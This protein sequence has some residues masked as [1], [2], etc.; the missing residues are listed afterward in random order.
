[1]SKHRR[2][3][4]PTASTT[5]TIGTNAPRGDPLYVKSSAP[6]GTNGTISTVDVRDRVDGVKIDYL[7]L[8]CTFNATITYTLVPAYSL[9]R[10]FFCILENTD[11]AWGYGMPM[12]DTHTRTLARPERL[13]AVEQA[14][15]LFATAAPVEG[16]V[17]LAARAVVAPIGLMNL[18]EATRLHVVGTHG[19]PDKVAGTDMPLSYSFCQYVVS[20]NAPLVIRDARQDSEYADH[21]AV[22]EYGTI[23]YLGYP[24]HGTGR[25][26]IGSLCV[27]DTVPRRW[28]DDDLAAVGEAAHL[29]E[30]TLA[31]EATSRELALTAAETDAV[32]ATTVEA[33]I[34]IE[35]NGRI[36][37][38]NSAAE[39]TFGWTA[40]QVVGKKV[41]DL[42][43]PERFRAAHR[44]AL[45]RLGTGAPTAGRLLGKRLQLW[46]IHRN[47]HEFPID[48]TL[49]VAEGPRG[50]RAHA[51]VYDI[52][53]RVAAERELT[54][55][56]RFLE[57]LL[58]SLDVGVAAV[59]ERGCVV[60]FNRAL[61]EAYGVEPDGA[62]AEEWV[63]RHDLREVDGRPMKP[64]NAPLARAFHGE[65]VR[66]AEIVVSPPGMPSRRFLANGQPIRD[67]DG[68][69]LGAV[70]AMHEVTER[71]R[72][73][74]F[75][76][77]ELTV[78]RVLTDATS[79]EEAGRGVLEAVA[80]TLRWPYA[81]MWLVDDVAKVLRPLTRWTD[82]E[83]AL[84]PQPPEVLHPGEGLAGRAWAQGAPVRIQNITEE[85]NQVDRPDLITQGLCVGLAIPVRGGEGPI[86]TLGFF[87]SV[88]ET[89][90]D[91]LIALL[92]GVAAHVGQYL[93][94]QRSAELAAELA[95]T[96]DEFIAL[97]G[98]EL[99]T[100]LT[101]ISAYT[102]LLLTDDAPSEQHREQF[103]GVIHRNAEHLRA[104]VD[105][106]LDLAGLESGYVV[107]STHPVDFAKLVHE[108]IAAI[109]PSAD[110]KGLAFVADL[111]SLPVPGEVLVDGDAARLRLVV[112]HILSN[113]VKY[114]P[115]GG[116]VEVKLEVNGAGLTLTVSD[117]GI[118]IPAEE[119]QRLFRRF[120]RGSNSRDRGIPGAGLGL[121]IARTIVDRHGGTITMRGRDTG[122]GTTFVVRLPLR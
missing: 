118:G 67:N 26:P 68:H 86:G 66:D 102:E 64:D 69:R 119:R 100:P 18:V 7:V 93:E 27:A 30:I 79:A 6:A 121:A 72:A 82:P 95:R 24:V 2:A 90:D 17:R 42:I 99:R 85:P 109:R 41:D 35:L 15:K 97:V 58:E 21:P 47:G 32:L 61:R 113:A 76:Q 83:S 23:A 96:K 14:R 10:A 71:R 25:E 63:I 91:T 44:A 4:T 16:L 34:S 75:M 49:N 46:A 106:L 78:N 111:D 120:F 84:D 39:Q 33:F 56:R 54:R 13:R 5:V 114:T 12:V 107:L 108:S 70:V 101:S 104:I 38:W 59:D 98:H 94:R 40:A 28:T 19:L 92:G 9:K 74:R 22:R 51:F 3:T 43:I 57:A 77:C 87:G 112:D 37:R 20:Q 116:R 89:V 80:R 48:M 88:P 36:E 81:E 55:G 50:R 8:T 105:D 110:G 65:R 62:T 60:L 1:M 31:A 115:A 53:E 122:P 103:L 73:E 117:T 11:R 45:N 52:T 29:L